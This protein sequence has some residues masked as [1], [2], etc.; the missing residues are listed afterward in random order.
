[1]Y[2]QFKHKKRREL[3]TFGCLPDLMA[4]RIAYVKDKQLREAPRP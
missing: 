2:C 1:M 3:P 4:S